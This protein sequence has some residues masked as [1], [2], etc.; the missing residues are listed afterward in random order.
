MFFKPININFIAASSFGNDWRCFMI[1]WIVW[2]TDSIALVVYTAFLISGENLKKGIISFQRF[3]QDFEIIGYLTSQTPANSSSAPAANSA[4]GERYIF[5]KPAVTAFRSLYGTNRTGLRTMCTMQSCTS[6]LG[7]TAAMASGN[8]VSPSTAARSI[9]FT[10]RFFSSF[11]IPIKR[12]TSALRLRLSI[13]ELGP[14]VLPNP[15]A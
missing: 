1:F 13:P 15:Q 9:S 14:L 10:P 6:V 12:G 2:L 3:R 7:N 4:D 8:P 11:M 5:F